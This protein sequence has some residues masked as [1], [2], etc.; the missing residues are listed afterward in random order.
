MTALSAHRVGVG[1]GE[2]GPEVSSVS[3]PSFKMLIMARY[4]LLLCPACVY[5]QAL[6]TWKQDLGKD[7]LQ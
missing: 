4:R 5:W 1:E 7:Y 3:L 6:E 2:D